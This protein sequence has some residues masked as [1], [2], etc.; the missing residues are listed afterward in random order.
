MGERVTINDL[1]RHPARILICYPECP[2]DVLAG[3]L[4][5]L[6]E[7]NVTSIVLVGRHRVGNLRF[8]GK[9]H[10]GVVVEAEA[11]GGRTA[12]KS[13]RSDAGRTSMDEEVRLLAAANAVG[14]GPRLI[15][16]STHFLL[17]E[18]V[19]G[20]YLRDELRVMTADD[21]RSLRRILRD[22]LSQA[23]KLDIVGIDHGE[24]VRLRRH[25]VL[26][27]G[28]PVIID[29]ESASTSRRVSNVTTVAQSLFLGSIVSGE[30]GMVLGPL[31]RDALLESLRRYRRCMDDE[32]FRAVLVAAGLC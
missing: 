4:A 32:A 3:R 12:L 23:R 6:G 22:L 10:T 30:I 27:S 29:F 2:E 31:D 16:W 8:L 15:S 17:M 18:L 25:V 21:G 14:V 24:L 26:R 1:S 20:P 13:L 5:E 11:S 9:G 19:E 7:L 28:S